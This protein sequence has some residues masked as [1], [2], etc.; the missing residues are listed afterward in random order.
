[1]L[2]TVTRFVG[3]R[4]ELVPRVSWKFL[5]ANE[6]TVLRHWSSEMIWCSRFIVVEK[7]FSIP[8][9]FLIP[10]SMVPASSMH[11]YGSLFAL[12]AL[13]RSI[14]CTCEAVCC[15][16]KHA[17]G[18]FKCGKCGKSITTVAR[19]QRHLQACVGNVHRRRTTPTVEL[20]QEEPDAGLLRFVTFLFLFVTIRL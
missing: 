3:D 16:P 6:R 14:W 20:E 17:A 12:V 11:I 2:R 4:H 18:S 13:A 10:F 15:M 8:S 9:Y 1:M 7:D 19:F 5:R